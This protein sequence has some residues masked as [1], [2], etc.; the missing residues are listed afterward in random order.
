VGE[1]EEKGLM[2]NF[3][4]VLEEFVKEGR[5]KVSLQEVFIRYKRKFGEPS[6]RD[7]KYMVKRAEE[8][9]Y[10]VR[11]DIFFEFVKEKF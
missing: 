2:E 9:G 10:W 3:I 7:F 6:W 4:S 5:N 1:K 11:K 8:E